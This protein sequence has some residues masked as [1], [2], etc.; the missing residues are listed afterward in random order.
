MKKK[1]LLTDD[2]ASAEH[3]EVVKA[4]QLVVDTF[5]LNEV[6]NGAV[7]KSIICLFLMTILEMKTPR[8]AMADIW[9]MLDDQL[10][11]QGD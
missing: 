7:N 6:S 2:P 5:K 1:F 4:M 8:L 10:K 3:A 11:T 9:K